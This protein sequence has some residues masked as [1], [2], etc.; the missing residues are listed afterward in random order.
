MEQALGITSTDHLTNTPAH[1][2]AACKVHRHI[3]RACHQSGAENADEASD[4]NGSQSAKGARG[5]CDRQRS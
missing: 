1:D 2:K 4:L 5:V 3:S